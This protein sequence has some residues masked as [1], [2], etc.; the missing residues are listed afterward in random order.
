METYLLY[1]GTALA[2]LSFILVII[3]HV[4]VSSVVKKYRQLIRGLSDKDV[5]DLMVSYAKELE[6]INRKLSNNIQKRLD[7]VE[8][9][10][11][12]CIRK[13]GMV[14]YNA[15]DNIGNN[16]SFSIAAL[17]DSDSG[18]VLT[19]IYARE[20]SYV[21]AKP[22]KTESRLTRNCRQRRKRLLA[23]L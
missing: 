18:L 20:N 13:F 2:A 15:F 3:N 6:H 9:K 14:T 17:D 7:V 12:S 16:M 10:L 11:P 21:Y 1:A 22:I 19:G 4:R 5:E 8:D 23:W